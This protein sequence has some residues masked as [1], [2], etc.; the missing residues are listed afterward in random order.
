MHPPAFMHPCPFSK[1]LCSED[2]EVSEVL[3]DLGPLRGNSGHSWRALGQPGDSPVR[4]AHGAAIGGIAEDGQADLLLG[5]GGL[6]ALA[7]SWWSFFV[8]RRLLVQ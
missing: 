7:F 8:P 4:N 6:V 3:T 5:D 2:L 1:E